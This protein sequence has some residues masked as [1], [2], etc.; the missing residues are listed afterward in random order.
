MTRVVI[1]DDH[2]I[3]VDGLKEL[4]Q[5]MDDIEVAGEANNG[6]ELL[7]LLSSTPADLVLLDVN[8]PEMDGIEATKAMVEQYPEVRILMLTMFDTQDYIQKLLRAGAHGYV[9]KNT[10]KEE[11]HL[12]IQTL[13]KGESYFSEEV[14]TRIMEGL[15]KKKARANDY[16]LVELTEREKEVLVLIAGEM[17]TREIADQLCV[18]HHTV[19]THR[20]NLIS[21]LNVRNVTG[22]VKYAV[23]QGWVD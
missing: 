19:E 21:K 12:A 17:T 16:R 15:Q 14:T 8:M 10:G 5:S 7:Q 23:Q 11:L 20:K 1:T 22:L 13:M 18:S 2:Q 6:K 4:L 3:F 9:L